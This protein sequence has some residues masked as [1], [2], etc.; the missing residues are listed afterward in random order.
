MTIATAKR[1]LQ[2]DVDSMTLEQLQKHRVELIDAWR[3]ATAAY[4]VPLAVKEGFYKI[5]ED[6]GASGYYPS[7][8][9]LAHNLAVKLD[10]VVMP[11]EAKMLK[12]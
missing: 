3:H 2:K 5:I 4:G 6:A 7:E 10:N 8:P 12:C 9:W 11:M 1:Y